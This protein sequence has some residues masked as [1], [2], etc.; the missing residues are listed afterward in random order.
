MTSAE[1]ECGFEVRSDIT[2]SYQIGVEKEPGTRT[3]ADLDV[4]DMMVDV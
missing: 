1:T 2:R 4:V 3:N